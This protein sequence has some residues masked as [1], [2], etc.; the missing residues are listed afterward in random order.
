MTKRKS[1][2]SGALKNVQKFF[3]KVLK[4]TDSDNDL[5]IEVLERDIR[6]AAKKNHTECAM[7]VAC[8]RAEHADGVIIS[9]NT[10]YVIKG[11]EATRFK[12]PQSI[13]R[14][15]VS[16]DRGSQF[17]PGDYALKSPRKSQRLGARQERSP[18][19]ATR[20]LKTKRRKPHV[21]EGVRTVLGSK[22]AA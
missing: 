3:P 17:G 1:N 8:K 12:V 16:F 14:E 22:L 13:A 4:V 15:V 20:P 7:A 11:N 9:V 2:A 6:A 21:T 19:T 18:S 5:E 10:A